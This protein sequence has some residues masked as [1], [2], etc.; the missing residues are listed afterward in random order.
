MFRLVKFSYQSLY[1]EIILQ[2]LILVVS[3]LSERRLIL[4][5]ISLKS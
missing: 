2:G 1:R 4:H 5:G 3:C